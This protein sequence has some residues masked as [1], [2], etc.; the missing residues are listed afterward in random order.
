MNSKAENRHLNVQNTPG[1]KDGK[2]DDLISQF[3][4]GTVQRRDF[5]RK[6]VALGISSSAAYSILNLSLI[7]I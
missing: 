4:A 3:R 7:H 1:N 6:I 5:L 2:L